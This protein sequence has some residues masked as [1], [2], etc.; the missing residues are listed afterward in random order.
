MER[1]PIQ[2]IESR[3]RSIDETLEKRGKLA[4]NRYPLLFGSLTTLG[5]MLVLYGF[6]KYADQT[7]F[8]FENPGKVF[9]VGIAIL[10]LTGS[11]YKNISK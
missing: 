10:L 11:L 7:A 5:I 4:H 6:E 1:D 8:I 9:W 2:Y 3:V